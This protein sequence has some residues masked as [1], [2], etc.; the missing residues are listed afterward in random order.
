MT[1]KDIISSDTPTNVEFFNNED[2]NQL[3]LT[4]FR[5]TRRNNQPNFGE[6]KEGHCPLNDDN[7]FI[8]VVDEIESG[9]ASKIDL[10]TKISPKLDN[11]KLE[12]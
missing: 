7:D 11:F 2:Y 6:L 1:L 3:E 5:T 12:A 9:K 8:D 10:N 4:D